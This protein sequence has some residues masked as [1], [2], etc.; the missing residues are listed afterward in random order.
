TSHARHPGANPARSEI[1]NQAHACAS[2][3]RFL[4]GLTIAP[5]K[6]DN[7]GRNQGHFGPKHHFQ[8][9]APRSR[10]VSAALH[11]FTVPPDSPLPSGWRAAIADALD[12]YG[13]HDVMDAIS[14]Y[15]ELR[16]RH[17][18]DNCSA[19]EESAQGGWYR[20]APGF[21][22]IA[23]P[24]QRRIEENALPGLPGRPRKQDDDG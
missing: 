7:G 8:P 19:A 1:R 9:V 16:C 21:R 10:A 5:R 6:C 18:P 11:P 20:S 13:V 22:K 4:L 17:E 14:A 12:R 15:A 2:R 24:A 3:D 23:G